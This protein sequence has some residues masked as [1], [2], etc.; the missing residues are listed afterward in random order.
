[1]NIIEI[2]LSSIESNAILTDGSCGQH[3]N[4]SDS[5]ID[6]VGY[7]TIRINSDEIFNRLLKYLV[8]HPFSTKRI[9]GRYFTDYASYN[10]FYSHGSWLNL[11]EPD[12][13]EW[14]LP[15][16]RNHKQYMNLLNIISGINDI[17]YEEYIFPFSEDNYV[18]IEKV[19]KLAA[20]CSEKIVK[21]YKSYVRKE[22]INKLLSLFRT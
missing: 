21:F 11:R 10:H 17:I 4:I 5:R 20:K 19:N 18:H 13:I 12:V 6:D 7:Y 22:R 15:K 16:Y 3:I 2:F 9:W 14:R 8:L 1:M